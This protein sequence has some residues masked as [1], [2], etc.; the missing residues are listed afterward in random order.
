MN[1]P[2]DYINW[3]CDTAESVAGTTNGRVAIDNQ[4]LLVDFDF[5]ARLDGISWAWQ[6]QYT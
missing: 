5:P 4:Y 6:P 1:L 2:A 3:V